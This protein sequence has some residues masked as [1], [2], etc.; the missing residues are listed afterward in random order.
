MPPAL[1][2]WQAVKPAPQIPVAVFLTGFH[3]GGTER[4]MIELIQ[5]LD[6]TRF[7]VHV[8]CFQ[9]AG[10]WLPRVE[11]SAPVTAFPIRG[12]AR[13]ATLARPAAVPR[14]CRAQR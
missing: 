10:A 1:L 6:R 13:P 9:H 5:R 3:P 4:Q 7:D 2:R 14:G 11:A 12:F 8:A